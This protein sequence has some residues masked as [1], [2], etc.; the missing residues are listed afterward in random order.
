MSSATAGTAPWG[1]TL[2]T[3]RLNARTVAALLAIVVGLALVVFGA[4]G[5]KGSLPGTLKAAPEIPVVTAAIPPIDPD[6]G[7]QTNSGKKTEGDKA[8]EDQARAKTDFFATEYGDRGKHEVT[9]TVNAGSRSSFLIHWRD[10]KSEKGAA[11]SLTRTRTITGGF[12]VAYVLGQAVPPATR[13]TCTIT[14]DGVQKVTQT[15]TG[16]WSIVSCLG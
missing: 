3:M 12:P 5:S 7:V 1:I 8:L 14:I 11:A 2:R 13:V 9:V 4:L 10:G 16:G 15:T 6:T